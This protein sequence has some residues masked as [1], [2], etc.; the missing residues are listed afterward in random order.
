M[1]D[2]NKKKLPKLNRF[3]ECQNFDEIQRR[4]I[5]HTEYTLCQQLKFLIELSP[6]RSLYQPLEGSDTYR[7]AF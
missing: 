7:D 4:M 5:S 2:R 6:F 1:A 3:I